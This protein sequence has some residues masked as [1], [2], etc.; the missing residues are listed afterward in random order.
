[1]K[2]LKN[3][4][5]TSNVL[6]HV[7]N[8]RN[9]MPSI[10]DTIK[11]IDELEK[12]ATKGPWEVCDYGREPSDG[13]IYS[14]GCHYAGGTEEKYSK[15]EYS[16]EAGINLKYSR[17]DVSLIVLLRNSWPA[18]REEME[19]LM[20]EVADQKKILDTWPEMRQTTYDAGFTSAK[21]LYEGWEEPRACKFCKGLCA[22]GAC[23]RE[24]K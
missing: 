9:D 13:F 1:M 7:K 5:S 20:E 6:N 18:I 12:K 10:Q 17:E 11:E 14:I 15:E 4:S 3:F 22:P 16:L 23:P 8:V 19:R 21:V 24:K 2:V